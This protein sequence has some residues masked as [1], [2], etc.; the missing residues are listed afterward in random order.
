[1]LNPFALCPA[2]TNTFQCSDFSKNFFFHFSRD[3]LISNRNKL[4]YVSKEF[5]FFCDLFVILMTVMMDVWN[6]FTW[7]FE[8]NILSYFIPYIFCAADC[9]DFPIYILFY[10]LVDPFW[11][12]KRFLCDSPS[13][14]ISQFPFDYH[15]GNKIK[16]FAPC[17]Q[18]K[19]IFPLGFYSLLVVPPV[20][21]MMNLFW[22]W[23]IAKGL[24]RNLSK[25]K[26][27]EWAY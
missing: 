23:K 13:H 19:E 7:W 6:K 5:K 15:L 4:L 3:C 14:I 8:I 18:V 26:H 2:W 27:S 24:V 16:R 21:T 20:L 9:K 17:F 1:M 22:F 12:G 25:A 10:P 11:W